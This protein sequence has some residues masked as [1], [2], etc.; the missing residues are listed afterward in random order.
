MKPKPR[1]LLAYLA[2]CAL[3]LAWAGSASAA[4]IIIDSETLWSSIITGS[5]PNGRPDETDDIF[6]E[7]GGKLW[8]NVSLSDTA[9]VRRF[10]AICHSITIGSGTTYGILQF[11]DPPAGV[12]RTLTVKGS[13]TWGGSTLGN[14]FV[15]SS[16]AP[17]VSTTQIYGSFLP[18]GGLGTFNPGLGA[19]QFLA[20]ANQTVP[21]LAFKELDL[22]GSGTK[23]V[24]AGAAVNGT[25]TIS[26]EAIVGGT[27]AITYGAQ[28]QLVYN[29]TV[30]QTTSLVE[31]PDRLNKPVT[32][33]NSSAEGVVLHAT[34]TLLGPVT[35]NGNL[36][37]GAA[38]T[39]TIQN[40]LVNNG[41]A[42]GA[43]KIILLPVSAT[44]IGGSAANP[45]VLTGGGEY[46][47]LQLNAYTRAGDLLVRGRLSIVPPYKL[48]L[49][50]GVAKAEWLSTGSPMTH[51]AAMGNWT[52]GANGYGA[53]NQD[54]ASSFSASSVDSLVVH[55]DLAGVFSNVNNVTRTYGTAS[56][57]LSGT[58]SATQHNN[59]TGRDYGVVY[60][61]LNSPVTVK[62]GELNAVT[63]NVDATGNF[64]TTAITI[65][66]LQVG[67]DHTIEY[68]FAS[69]AMLAGV[70][71]TAT[72][73]R[74]NPKE[75]FIRPVSASKVYGDV[76]PT[77]FAF[78]AGP[79][80]GPLVASPYTGVL[81]GTDKFAGVLGVDPNPA[82]VPAYIGRY[83]HVGAYD[84]YMKTL[85]VVDTTGT[86]D[87]VTEGK[88]VLYL[89]PGT[90]LSITPRPL[91]ITANAQ[92][93]TYGDAD[94]LPYSKTV[95][96]SGF[97][98][99]ETTSGALVREEGEHAGT[100]KITQGTLSVSSD[101][102]LT[103]IEG[104]FTIAQRSIKINVPAVDDVG[105]D[106]VNA[107]VYGT[108][109]PLANLLYDPEAPVA[110][111]LVVT[112]QERWAGSL[113]RTD[114]D[115]RNAGTYTL[116]MGDP[117]D[118][119]LHVEY[120]DVA[121]SSWKK[122]NDYAYD[123]P[124]GKEYKILKK[125]INLYPAADKDVVYGTTFDVPKDFLDLS[126]LAYDDG[127]SALPGIS[128][129]GLPTTA[130]PW[131]PKSSYEYTIT[132]SASESANYKV[133]VPAATG[134]LKITKAT[135]AV[136]AV[137]KSKKADGI[138]YN[139][140]PNSFEATYTGWV[141][142]DTAANSLSGQIGWTGDAVEATTAGV[143][144][145]MPA[146]TTPT[147]MLT[148]SKYTL[149]AI[150]GVL[151]LTAPVQS[152]DAAVLTSGDPISWEIQQADG[153][154]GVS[155]TL[156][157]VDENDTLSL[158]SD[159]T[160]NLT[161][162][163]DTAG[164]PGL[165]KKWDPTRIWKWK[166]IEGAAYLNGYTIHLVDMD[167][168]DPNNVLGNRVGLFQNNPFGGSF[169]IEQS[170][171]GSDVYIV[172][173][174]KAP[175]NSEGIADWSVGSLTDS[176][177]LL[178]S[179]VRSPDVPA[180]YL[181]VQPPSTH[182]FTDQVVIHLKA[183]NLRVFNPIKYFSGVQAYIAFSSDV[184]KADPDKA[185]APEVQPYSGGDWGR[186][187]TS[188][189]HKETSTF[190]NGGNGGNMDMVLGVKLDLPNGGTA[191]DATVYNGSSTIAVIK[192]TP[193]RSKDWKSR[194]MFR[195]D[196]DVAG[197]KDDK[198]TKLVD[199]I[200]NSVYPARV[201]SEPIIMESDTSKPSVQFVK[202]EQD[203]PHQ[204]APTYDAPYGYGLVN[205][206]GVDTDGNGGN[207]TVR[208]TVYVYVTA[209]DNGSGLDGAP[210]VTI[211]S[212]TLDLVS[213]AAPEPNQPAAT[214]KYKWEVT[215]STPNGHYVG[216]VNA[217]DKIGNAMDEKR[218][219]LRV[220]VREVQ[221]FVELEQFAGANR[222]V[223]IY[224]D[225]WNK[226][227][228]FKKNL[229]L[230][231][232]STYFVPGSTTNREALVKAMYAP[233][234]TDP[235]STA[236]AYLYFGD[237][238]DTEYF[239]LTQL[240]NPKLGLNAYI[241][242]LE[243]GTIPGLANVVLRLQ[244][245]EREFDY[246][247]F[248]SLTPST[249]TALNAYV[250]AGN[251]VTEA[252]KATLE[253]ALLNDFTRIINGTC[254][255]EPAR[256]DMLVQPDPL[257]PAHAII[258]R[259]HDID[260]P[261]T[262]LVTETPETDLINKYKAWVLDS[263]QPALSAAEVRTLNRWLLADG[264]WQDFSEGV[265]NPYTPYLWLTYTGGKPAA[266]ATMKLLTLTDLD[267]L[268]GGEFGN[269]YENEPSRFFGV[270]FAADTVAKLPPTIPAGYDI[271]KLNRMLLRDAYMD[272]RSTPAKQNYVI[273]PFSP[274]TQD[275]MADY[276][277]AKTDA[278]AIQDVDYAMASDAKKL[279]EGGLI[280]TAERFGAFT[281]PTDMKAQL[282]PNAAPTGAALLRLNRRILEIA[283]T[284]QS[285]GAFL[286]S[287]GTV[288][289][290]R[291]TDVPALPPTFV[292]GYYKVAA[293]AVSP[294][295][296]G[297]GGMRSWTLKRVKDVAPSDLGM[298]TFVNDGV[299]EWS[300]SSDYYLR[301]GDMNGDE[302]IDLV[303]F[304]ILKGSYLGTGSDQNADLD[305]NG[306]VFDR[307]YF[308]LK[309]NWLLEGD[310]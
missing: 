191:G 210:T 93:K 185:G 106:Y 18:P 46:G 229:N 245:Q 138:A 152:V 228:P 202:A 133:A 303:D 223:T 275:A 287:R 227:D 115:N 43:G 66:G 161:T 109:A 9:A 149:Q 199:S 120:Y 47:N 230:N 122:S 182:P 261:T 278:G 162:V 258:P 265:L 242:E 288:A 107:K 181:E 73:L 69:D 299:P 110:P 40:T 238:L 137:N 116:I 36:D 35:I 153:T 62:V 80:A 208:G 157:K 103:F 298:V 121:S 296:T 112:Y 7:K 100:Y 297:S 168:T 132:V 39:L 82:K 247:V 286:I 179:V 186:L 10:E 216:Y 119:G 218:F 192:L 51:R 231:F 145:I 190:P 20:T 94:T 67:V 246:F 197:Q 3:L 96:G 289:P 143:Y 205:V 111:N 236:G 280:Y 154:A 141:G 194:V 301:V 76:D 48:E 135:L 81:V 239:V 254:I 270:K 167:P 49:T 101:Y 79:V 267:R 292:S 256:F 50:A 123:F 164:T 25:L 310:K 23:T 136:R 300:D 276:L 52:T 291:L 203:Q 124:T 147:T 175:L 97:V 240:T 61:T 12:S 294:N 221:G 114:K 189:T 148:S 88:Y 226:A 128:L 277:A 139:T 54:P 32:F 250:A 206:A 102:N 127:V 45:M 282:P 104:S 283:F 56:I 160:V 113:T 1:S 60:P 159:I 163:S 304:N 233:T 22:M 244:K 166:F 155:W 249:I 262:L 31:L 237:I 28:S 271:I 215:G 172:F 27:S 306:Q 142:N 30:K 290:Y 281:F 193:T 213:G 217:K 158:G 95:S 207:T 225:A 84:L 64:T 41:S 241:H 243:F 195:D 234:G 105:P 117:N 11:D 140:P 171:P 68:A 33:A 144:T 134:K 90:T 14:A 58:V 44:A 224:A 268:V 212:A 26:E 188:L 211:G 169:S 2:V 21:A 253:T 126:V 24:T 89:I 70:N 252:Q 74:I 184:F 130:Q 263:T 174:P 55:Y 71:N 37:I 308:L 222:T 257:L 6:I 85:T 259:Q 285:S 78:T 272:S 156:F 309:Q 53:S 98:N 77:S 295:A 13:V 15:M 91:T 251:N 260:D 19:V 99:S 129:P 108:A 178:G 57:T 284:D 42:F 4:N 29:G 235:V 75:I 131:T 293:K 177:S 38:Y 150:P 170:S 16:L 125:S 183:A 5:G 305:G 86:H 232:T 72:H 173:T 264:Y 248:N 165:M 196:V 180:L 151:T 176:A 266:Y 273:A 187:I 302:F 87:L 307:D 8:V 201:M 83:S 204:V 255:Y 92:G 63:A 17:R 269:L 65:S 34:R 59:E 146:F 274:E 219:D 214:F 118:G 200:G 220:N 279:L 209:T 198:I